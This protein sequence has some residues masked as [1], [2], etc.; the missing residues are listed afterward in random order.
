MHSRISFK[1]LTGDLVIEER[2]MFNPNDIGKFGCFSRIFED[3]SQTSF[4][5]ETVYPVP[6]KLAKGV[7]WD[8]LDIG[9]KLD[10][11]VLFTLDGDIWRTDT[12]A[13]FVN[14]LLSFDKSISFVKGIKASTTG[15]Y[16]EEASEGNTYDFFDYFVDFERVAE[17]PNFDGLFVVRKKHFSIYDIKNITFPAV[18]LFF[19]TFFSRK[20]KL[21]YDEQQLA[22]HRYF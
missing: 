12:G 8:L 13:C 9:F 15:L 6:M 11:S 16:A 3:I 10:V 17:K 2:T 21:K 5:S 19:D 18:Q 4:H 20:M 22:E 1:K 14:N 7:L